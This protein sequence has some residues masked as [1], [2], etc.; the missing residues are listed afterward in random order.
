MPTKR[1]IL[2]L[3][4]AASAIVLC[5]DVSEP[6]I[7][8]LGP[9]ATDTVS[10]DQGK[11]LIVSASKAAAGTLTLS[12]Q[13]VESERFNLAV[14]GAKTNFV[15]E[16]YKFFDPKATIEQVT[17]SLKLFKGYTKPETLSYAYADTVSIRGL[18]QRPELLRFMKDLQ[19]STAS[20]LILTARG[21]KDTTIE[22]V[23]DDPSNDT[24]AL[25][26]LHVQLVPG[27]NAVFLAPAGQK[28]L[29]LLYATTL[30]LESVPAADRAN[31][32]HFSSFEQTCTSCHEGLPSADAGATMSADCNVCHKAK[33]GASFLHAPAE[34]KECGS[35]HSWSAEKK[36][37]VVESGVPAA[38]YTC[39]DTKQAQVESSA[40]PHPVA[41]EC[42]TCHSSHGTEQKHLLKSDVFT[43]C[44]SC[45]EEQKLNHPVG[46]HPMRFAKLPNGEEMTCAT[47]HNPHGSPNARMFPLPVDRMEL[48]GACHG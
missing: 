48:C 7:T 30:V 47:C 11:L 15:K 35:C 10:Y 22:A 34:M 24:R 32:F 18:W 31:R 9:A 16:F 1:Q 26:K 41:S 28:S 29:A 43:L 4:L 33:T 5:G 25:Y 21:W 19:A 37:V 36:S 20:E 3:L 17:F 2:L 12:S 45:H 40:T 46:R 27:R 44:T 23:Y 39:H 14:E 13:W 8:I 38:C 6:T 42:M